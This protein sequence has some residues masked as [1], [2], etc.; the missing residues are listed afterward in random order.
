MERVFH[1]VD[2]NPSLT[3]NSGQAFRWRPLNG[4]QTEWIG[5]I[6]GTVVKISESHV[7]EL[8]SILADPDLDGLVESYFTVKDNLPEIVSTFQRDDLIT[9]AVRE[10]EGLRLLTQDP[11]ECLISFVCSI[12]C[13]IPSIRQKIE[14]LARRYGR[15]IETGTS[16]YWYSFP[17]A[18]TLAMAEKNDLLQCR[19]G[20]RWRYVS[21]I[22]KKVANGELD[23][24]GIR[25]LP[26]AEA[27]TR[28]MSEFTDNT[29]GV[30]PK[31]ADCALLYSFHKTEAFPIDIWILRCMKK[32]Y[33]ESIGLSDY[34]N[35]TLKK[36]DVISDCMRRRFGRYAGYAQLYLY[37]KMRSDHVIQGRLQA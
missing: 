14:N 3:L 8:G 21:F 24:D 6:S 10:F 28:L 17:D 18:E 12:N 16:E 25:K 27:R 31:V 4:P 23:L 32:Y 5:I 33:S 7:T 29:L 11:W 13:N 15:K 19:L 9:E 35:L 2:F 30:G 22:A 36:Y 26:Y 34:D 20:F 37:A 1:S